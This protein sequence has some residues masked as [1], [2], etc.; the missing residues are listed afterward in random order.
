MQQQLLFSNL[1]VPG[2]YST[3]NSIIYTGQRT[4]VETKPTQASGDIGD[5]LYQSMRVHVTCHTRAK[6]DRAEIAVIMQKFQNF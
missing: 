4:S 1:L 5:Q 2:L 3:L 6:P